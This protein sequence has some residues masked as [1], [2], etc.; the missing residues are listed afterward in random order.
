MHDAGIG[1]NDGQIAKRGLSPAQEGVALFV[2]DEFKFGI[3]L[4]RLRRAE[5]VHLH[6]VIDHQFRRLQ[7]D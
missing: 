5:F 2:A 1:R 6:R 7:R 4:K 3:E